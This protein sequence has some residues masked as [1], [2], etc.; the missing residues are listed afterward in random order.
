[1]G[2][3]HMKYALLSAGYHDRDTLLRRPEIECVARNFKMGRHGRDTL[4][5][6]IV[7]DV[8]TNYV[9]N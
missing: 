3:G 5:Q 2:L 6:N 9:T 4:S 8:S 7:D 1:M